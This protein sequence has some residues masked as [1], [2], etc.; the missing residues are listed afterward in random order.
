MTGSLGIYSAV[1]EDSVARQLEV[2]RQYWSANYTGDSAP[3]EERLLQLLRPLQLENQFRIESRLSIYADMVGNKI[4]ALFLGLYLGFTFLLA[5]TAV[6]ALQQ[7]SQAADNTGRYAILRRLGAEERQVKK[8]A[9]QQVALAFLLPLLLAV[10][11]SVVGMKA[12]NDIISSV[13]RVDSAASSMIT[14]GVLL[15]VYGGYFLATSL[16]CR[17]MAK[18][19]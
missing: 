5:A 17:R 11:H 16:A 12:A 7:L 6:L 9:T 1:V 15:A 8:S 3:T 19:A 2:R 10:V 18:N 14:A 13:G 4:L